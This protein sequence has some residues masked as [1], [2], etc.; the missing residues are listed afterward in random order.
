MA[1][2]P[3]RG[4]TWVVG[5]AIVAVVLVGVTA[6]VPTDVGAQPA[7]DSAVGAT[8]GTAISERS[9]S[10]SAP[11]SNETQRCIACHDDNHPGMVKQFEQSEHYDAGV[12]CLDCHGAKDTEKTAE[13]HFGSVISPLVTPK[14]CEAC[15]AEETQEFHNS[16]HD[17]AAFFSASAMSN[18]DTGTAAMPTGWNNNIK[19]NNAR[20]SAEAGCQECHGANL[21]VLNDDDPNAPEDDVTIQGHPNQGMGRLNPDGSIGSCAACHPQHRFSIEQARTGANPCKEC[22]LGP[23][24]PQTEI[25]EESK[26]SSMFHANEDEFNLSVDSEELTAEDVTAPSC[27][28]CHMSGLGDS[29]STHDVSSRLKWEA[30]PVYSWPTSK[31]YETGEERYPIAD[32]VATHYEQQYNLSDGTIESVPTGAPNPFAALETHRPDLYETYVVEN[33][34]TYPHITEG[35]EPTRWDAFGGESQVSAQVKRERMKR[36]CTE[37]HTQEWVNSEFQKRDNVIDIYNAV[38]VAA[39]TKY[40]EEIKGQAPKAAPYDQSWVD[41]I[42]FEMWHHEG[43]RWRMGAL[44]KGQD[45]EHWDGSY[46]VKNDVVKLAHFQSVYENTDAGRPAQETSESL[47]ADQGDESGTFLDWLPSGLSGVG[48]GAVATVVGFGIPIA[49]LFWW[50]RT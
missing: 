17:E 11:V 32:D 21:K 28:I 1:T 40:Y 47:Q 19:T 46:M 43:R 12:N 22:H 36:I 41:S 8:N 31:Q 3:V 25:Y 38:F 45:Y 33:D 27:A 13:T 48:L 34:E 2:Y 37:C 7:A 35:D 29:K 44:M 14:D 23:D 4:I 39:E 49:G 30:E 26:H 50:R 18:N 24:H 15:H 6:A 42:Y 20:A 16:L 5:L 10:Q 9:H